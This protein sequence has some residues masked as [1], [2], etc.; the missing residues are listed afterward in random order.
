MDALIAFWGQALA[1]I[2][3]AALLMWRVIEPSRQPGQRLLLA[4]FAMTCAWA[5]LSA[6][7][8]G[9]GLAL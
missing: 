3:F 5:W 4:A 9:G 8:P 1:A 7:D 2:A 6:I